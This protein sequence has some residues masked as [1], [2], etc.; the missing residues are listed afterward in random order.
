MSGESEESRRGGAA[1][2]SPARLLKILLSRV[3]AYSARAGLLVLT[4][5][6]EGV[7]N[8]LL[9]LSLKLIIDYAVA[10]RRAAV[11]A[12]ILAALGLGF[13]LTAASQVLRDYLYAWLGSHII[14]DMRAE[15]FRHLQRLSPAFYARARA[16]DLSARF[17][18]DLAA[19]E[20]AVVLGI[21]GALLC[22]INILFSAC[23]LFVLDWRLALCAAAG[24]PLCVIGP[25]LLAPRALRE[26][27]RLRDEQAAL[28]NVIHEN[29]GAQ[30]VVRAFGLGRSVLSG[31]EA[32]G[33]KVTGLAT[34]FNF[35][36]Y[37][38]ERS[39][40]IGMLLFNVL[41]IGIGSYLAYSGSLSVGSLV[42]FNALF[43][44]VSTAVMGLT[45]VTP[46]LLQATG[47]MRR[48][49]EILDERPTVAEKPDAPALKS[50]RSSIRF[51]RVT[52]GYTPERSNLSGVTL[53]VPAG[54]RVAFVGHSGSGKSTALSLVMRFYDPVEGAVLFDGV[55]LREA[56]PDSLYEQ[57]GVVFQ[58]SFLFNTSVR[59]NIRM[60]RTAATDAEVEEAARAAEIHD[61]IT[62]MHDG[63]DTG[64]GERGGLLSG[65]QRQRVAIA[66][67]LVRNPSVIILDEA[68]SALD[69]GSEAAIN[70]TVERVSAGRTVI[71]VT[72]RLTSVV[73][74]DHIFVFH[75]GRLIEQGTHGELLR[76][77]GTYAGMWRRQTGTT[78][79]PNGDLFVTDVEILRDVPLFKDLDRSY[80]QEISDMLIAERVPKGRT[81][82]KEG[83]EGRRFY[84]VARGKVAVSAADD[85]GR[86]RRLAILE[87]GDFFGEIALLTDSPTTATVETLT[88]STFLVLQREQ[89]QNLM[90][91][92][93]ALGAQVRH[94]LERRAA[95]TC[96][97][98]L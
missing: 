48:V 7:F 12:G 58:E 56:R 86:A 77:G 94:A 83:E 82:I 10:P 93:E 69:P 37:V 64:V 30:S 45:A 53:E 22:V 65:G 60:G 61:I 28:T 9:A 98:D 44:T 36:S 33:S 87:D 11:L 80:L 78:V 97:A 5:L 20:N 96:A 63:Y 42:S 75:E 6:V 72:H 85:E 46:T 19:V 71:S 14:A 32:Q 95:E 70:E 4:L 24:L 1:A 88:Q 47:G 40:N 27:D 34:R 31:F 51:E 38:S 81:I 91:R 67:A 79:A 84:I 29:L 25:K 41:L 21:P 2:M 3:R 74:Y 55:D 89:L 73:G 16:G 66:R 8:V 57:L 62:R 59:E 68:T 43:I 17:S 76:R 23:V 49:R 52:F 90:R 92:H 54:T 26:G 35:L 39:P 50:L 18:S 15:M 13:L